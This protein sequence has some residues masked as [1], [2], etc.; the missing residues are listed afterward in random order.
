MN[1]YNKLIDVLVDLAAIA[2]VLFIVA[3][4][5]TGIVMLAMLTLKMMGVIG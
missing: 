1:I 3:L 2:L 4:P 5:V